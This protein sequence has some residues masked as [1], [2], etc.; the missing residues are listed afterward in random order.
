MGYT[1]TMF[2]RETVTQ[3]KV[4]KTKYKKHVLVESYR[5]EKGPRQRVVMQLGTLTLPKSEWKKLAAA[6]E[7]RL[8]GQTTLFEDDKSIAEA[9]EKAMGHFSFTK[10]KTHAKEERQE[11]GTFVSVDL[12]SITTAESR[13]LGPELVGHSLWNRLELNDILHTCGFTPTQ[14]ALAEA[15]VVGRLIEPSS[16]LASWRWLRER[17]AL[18]EL[19]PVDLSKVGKDAVYEIADELLANK[20]EIERELR[21]KEMNLFPRDNQVFLFDLTNTYF[22]GSA[23]NNELAKRGKSK[24]KR[25]DCPLVTLALV[26]DDAGFPI[27]SQIY[28]GN[29]SEPETLEEIL[30]RLDT[31]AS[32]DLMNSRP[33]IAMDRGIA[34]KDNLVLIKEKEFPYIVV[35]RRAVEKEYKEEFKYAKETFEKI[36]PRNKEGQS[37]ST[38]D[39]VSESIYVKK[40]PIEKGSRVLCLSEGRELKEMAM[41]ELKENRFLHD[42]NRLQTSVEKGNIKLVDKVGERIGRLKERYSSIAKY[43][44][45]HLE[46]DEKEEKVTAITYAKKPTR[47]ERSVLTGCYVIET[48][49]ESLA[50][51]EIWRLYTTLTKIEAAF[52][53]LKTDLG[54]RP[55]YHQLADRTRGH[56]FISVLAYH[57]LISME[58]QLREQG[59]HRNWSTIKAQLSTHQRTTVIVTDE[60]DQIHHIR[61][62]GTIEKSHKEIYKLLKVKDPLKRDYRIA[63]KRL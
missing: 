27:F 23:Q 38:N 48:S 59:D 33:M 53:A 14:Q 22:E 36:T 9:T 11:K 54:V 30:D 26:V 31:D 61:V 24:E 28:G 63:G 5:T 12:E 25:T 4:T 46:L 42:L 2:I 47:K 56:L 18:T 50:A 20:D 21:D 40:V 13:S 51:N 6:L 19:L 45:I 60:E 10:K 1:I 15:V 41:D 29:Q 8:A 34:T 43:Y 39:A 35:E 57:L 7:G 55:V 32:L 52:R 49:D 3:N 62:S 16:D 44:E 58:Y 17:T 37:L